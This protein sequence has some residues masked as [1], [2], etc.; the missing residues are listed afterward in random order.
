MPKQ[1]IQ[2]EVEDQSFKAF[3]E[4][5]GKFQQALT[6]AQKKLDEVGKKSDEAGKKGKNSFENFRKELDSLSRSAQAVLTPLMKIGSVIYDVAK[7]AAS[8]AL[9]FAKWLAFGAIG[10]GFGLGGLASSVVNVGGQARSAGMTSGQ[11]RA[12]KTAYGKFDIDVEGLLS[13]ITEARS[14]P[15]KWAAFQALGVTNPQSGSTAD[16]LAQVLKGGKARAGEAIAG[17]GVKDL[18]S[19]LLGIQE[20]RNLQGLS[21]ERL[22]EAAR[23]QKQ[24]APQYETSE[25]GW[26][27]FF[28]ALQ[29]AGQQIETSLIKNLITLTPVLSKLALTISKDLNE[30]LTSKGFHEGLKNFGDLILQFAKYLGSKDFK[31]DILAFGKGLKEMTEA[32][33]DVIQFIRHP[34][35]TTMNWLGGIGAS[36]GSNAFDA[37]QN[38]KFSQTGVN[39][40]VASKAGISQNLLAAQMEILHPQGKGIDPSTYEYE[41]RST[42]KALRSTL[43]KYAKDKDAVLETLAA[44]NFGGTDPKFM[45]KIGTAN[46]QNDQRVQALTKV[47]QVNLVIH[48]ATAG[49]I[50]LN[51]ATQGAY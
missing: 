4:A 13:K 3:V 46:W 35:D 27:D 33:F 47:P 19:P 43:A 38:L 29:E 18:I 32:I 51:A 8:T 45:G 49:N 34:L 21:S 36:I 11:L 17:G 31:A 41:A 42:A 10:S 2:I 28:Q 50:F 12:A 1:V 30:L 40:D 15:S 26:Q 44:Y 6:D 39:K 48:D 5:F 9:S 7:S 20:L 14:D 37:M 23:R 16:I 25:R 24:L 22:Y